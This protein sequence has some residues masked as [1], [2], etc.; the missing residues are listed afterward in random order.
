LVAGGKSICSRIWGIA[1]WIAP[2]IMIDWR[3]PNT[4][5]TAPAINIQINAVVNVALGFWRSASKVASLGL[6][7][8]RS[9]VCH[10]SDKFTS[11]LL[12]MH[13]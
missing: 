10:V 6:V 7:N 8:T 3:K 2:A 13:F 1:P 11:C 12:T 4:P 9:Q 5:V